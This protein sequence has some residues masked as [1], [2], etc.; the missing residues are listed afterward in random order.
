MLHYSIFV[1]VFAA[2]YTTILQYLF[3]CADGPR[4]T[5]NSNTIALIRI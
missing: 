5:S 4:N 3:L 2:N 1:A